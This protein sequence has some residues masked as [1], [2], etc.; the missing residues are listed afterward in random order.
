MSGAP[1]GTVTILGVRPDLRARHSWC[2]LAGWI[3]LD[4]GDGQTCGARTR[5]L[6]DG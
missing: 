2:H 3:A 5:D 4:N 6:S 1:E